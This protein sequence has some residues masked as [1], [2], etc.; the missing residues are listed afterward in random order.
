MVADV[1]EKH[2]WDFH[3]KS[4]S[5]GPCRLFLHVLGKNRSS[6]NVWENA[7][8]S[9]TSFFQKTFRYL[10]RFYSLLFHGFF[11]AFQWPFRGP[12]LSRKRVFGPFSWLFRRG[13]VLHAQASSRST[14]LLVYTLGHHVGVSPGEDTDSEW[15]LAPKKKSS[16]E[17]GLAGKDLVLGVSSEDWVEGGWSQLGLACRGDSSISS[18]TGCALLGGLHRG[19]WSALCK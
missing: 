12:L 16:E 14:R 4:G 15:G 17:C 19:F 10:W 1:W 6:K 13:Q 18:L 9:Q 5:S 2:G 11:V 3:A 7:W 8:K